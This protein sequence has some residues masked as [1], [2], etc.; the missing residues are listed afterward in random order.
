M[1]LLL[2]LLSVLNPFEQV[3]VVFAELLDRLLEVLYLLLELPFLVDALLY[4]LGEQILRV[5][6]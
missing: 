2:A 1:F 3:F 4:G 6:W 5:G